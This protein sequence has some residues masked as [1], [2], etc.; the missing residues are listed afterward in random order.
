LIRPE[1]R[2]RFTRPS[3]GSAGASA[4]AD[5]PDVP[6][7]QPIP[8]GAPSLDELAPA[9]VEGWLRAHP[10]RVLA[11]LAAAAVF[12]R[13][14][15]C[16]QVAGGPLPRLHALSPD[17]DNAFF[18]AWGR[19][20]AGG[21]LLQRAP[22]H[23]MAS[24][25]SLVAENA[26][27]FDPGLAAGLGLAPGA[28]P[29]VAQARL[30]DRW[31]GGPT[32]FQEPAYPY[33]VGLTYWIA[34]PTPWAVFAWQLALGVA[35]VLLAHALA[36]RQFG[37]AA[38]AAAGLLAALA[39]VPLF[40]EV[41]L[42][43]DTLVVFATLALAL[44][45]HW[46]VEG[47]RRRWLVLG[48]AFGAA[49]LVKQ[50]FLAFPLLL[51]GWRLLARRAPAR[52]RLAAAGLVVAGMALALSP[53][54]ARNLAVGVPALALNGSAATMLPMFHTAQATPFVVRLDD[55][56]IRL[57]LAGTDSPLRSLLEAA[58][59]HDGAWPFLLLELRKLAYAWHGFE[60]HNNVDFYLFRQ[61]APVLEALPAR[62][63]V[64]VPLA[65][66][67]LARAAG[68][69]W[70]LLIAILA[71][72]AGLVLATVLARFR[73]PLTVA[74]L[75]LAGAGAVQ[76]A[77][78][79]AAR[80][81]RPLAAAAVASALYL[82]WASADP[83]G[84]SAAVR[85]AEYRKDGVWFAKHD[86]ALG[87]LY[88]LEA[89]RLAPASPRQRE[90]LG[91]L[92]LASGDAPAAVPHLAAAAGATG[93]AATRLL[94]ARALAEA[95]RPEEALAEVRAAVAADP[96]APEGRALLERLE[97]TLQRPGDG[98][99]HGGTP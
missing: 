31:L 59:T 97:Q 98:A 16:L 53:A 30:W 10:R 2:P 19:Q 18:D 52:E 99:R 60:A 13:L 41:T 33:L 11:G 6:R 78:W 22:W 76:L 55:D 44:L 9:E 45:M 85:A 28:P 25:M 46:A 5:E 8:D 26:L 74:L 38:G 17:T 20:V 36:R 62:M 57:L 68:R 40:Y 12:V 75:P 91:E 14:L 86:P 73:A 83:P 3:A 65:A 96:A 54:V 48:L 87:A 67:G 77:A 42:L 88:L 4:A 7:G 81:W 92:L 58:R 37:H 39:P 80:R 35:T 24:W 15:L 69:A 43:R 64:L 82:P 66:V 50:T 84:R 94:L 27:R 90:R 34:G 21:D 71:S 56:Y 89:G 63:V 23:P 32:F 1:G 47:P 49:A 72:V 79:L 70:P 51:A 61:A 93:A 95:G 29:A